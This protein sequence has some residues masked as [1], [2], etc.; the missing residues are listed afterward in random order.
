MRSNPV[1][2]NKFWIA[3]LGI[4]VMA[5]ASL[6]LVLRQAPATH[7]LVYSDGTLVERLELAGITEPYDINVDSGMGT[8]II[9]V[10]RGR[11]RISEANCPDNSCVR[12]GWISG[13]Y[14]PIVCLPHRLVITLEGSGDNGVDAIVG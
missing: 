3:I 11:I 7:A 14:T 8:N 4:I 12:L 6:T 10:E 9:T 13:G 5:S 1:K 2:S